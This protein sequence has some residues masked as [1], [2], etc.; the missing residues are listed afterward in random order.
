[1]GQG[2]KF[3]IVL[4]NSI[5][6]IE[7]MHTQTHILNWNPECPIHMQTVTV[8]LHFSFL[9]LSFASHA[10]QWKFL[11]CNKNDQM[12]CYYS[13]TWINEFTVFVVFY[14]F[15]FLLIFLSIW[16]AIIYEIRRIIAVTASPFS[17]IIFFFALSK[18][19]T[20]SPCEKYWNAS[21]FQPLSEHRQT[22]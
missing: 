4:I 9:V 1:M 19:C 5:V 18:C 3:H 13:Y 15:D 12:E 10:E 14:F 22:T 17:F 20:E 8:F 11:V 7:I 6:A 16:N 21:L 2:L